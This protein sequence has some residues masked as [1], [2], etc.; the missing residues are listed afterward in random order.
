MGS[1]VG[2]KAAAAAAGAATAVLGKVHS[3][4]HAWSLEN[5][6]GKVPSS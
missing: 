1:R 5:A 6:L 4:A 2:I 3:E